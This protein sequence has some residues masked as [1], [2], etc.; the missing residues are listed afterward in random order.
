MRNSIQ[1][2]PF[3]TT[4]LPMT[5]GFATGV[6]ESATERFFDRIA[7]FSSRDLGARSSRIDRSYDDSNRNADSLSARYMA[8]LDKVLKSIA[9]DDV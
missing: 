1:P 6:A 5:N 4:N 8:L 7:G 3:H 2:K 9:A